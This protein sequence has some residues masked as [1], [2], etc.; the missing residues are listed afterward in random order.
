L[1]LLTRYSNRLPRIPEGDIAVAIEATT[2]AAITASR[3]FE[4][5]DDLLRQW[6]TAGVSLLML[7][8]LFG[9]AMIATR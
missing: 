2:R 1:Q 3:R 4:R 7:A 9:A 5:V 8:I 6:P